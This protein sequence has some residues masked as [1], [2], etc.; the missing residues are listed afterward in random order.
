MRKAFC[1]IFLSCLFVIYCC[2]SVC[3]FIFKKNVSPGTPSHRLHERWQMTRNEMTV[4]H[5]INNQLMI[6]FSMEFHFNTSLMFFFLSLSLYVYDLQR[7]LTKDMITD[8]NDYLTMSCREH[9]HSFISFRFCSCYFIPF[10]GTNA[11]S[12]RIEMDLSW[13]SADKQQPEFIFLR[14]WIDG[15]NLCIVHACKI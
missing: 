1:S 5:D 14:I 4:Q 11:W 13:T 7:S 6:T 8:V 3:L 12:N 10:I 2:W 9:I 15:I